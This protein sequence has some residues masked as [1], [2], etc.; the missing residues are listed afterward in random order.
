[1]EVNKYIPHSLL[2]SLCC[3]LGGSSGKLHTKQEVYRET[4]QNRKITTRN[5]LNR[6]RIPRISF[7][8]FQCPQDP[9]SAQR[10]GYIKPPKLTFQ[11][12]VFLRFSRLKIFR[13]TP[14]IIPSTPIAIACVLVYISHPINILPESVAAQSPSQPQP[15]PHR[16][17]R[18]QVLSRLARFDVLIEKSRSHFSKLFPRAQGANRFPVFRRGLHWVVVSLTIF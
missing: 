7:P 3:V 5:K 9:P 11:P 10:S 14:G 18:Q 16:Y 4:K 2:S 15:Q 17:R 13:Q 8:N 6:D 12:L 1:M